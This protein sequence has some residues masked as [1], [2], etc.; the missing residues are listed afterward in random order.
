[1]PG[2]VALR[3]HRFQLQ[4]GGCY[5]TQ[6][7]GLPPQVGDLQVVF[8]KV[9]CGDLTVL[10]VQHEDSFAPLAYTMNTKGGKVV[11]PEGGGNEPLLQKRTTAAVLEAADKDTELNIDGGCCA[12][13]KLVDAAV[14]SRMEVYEL[15]ESR[16][17]CSAMLARAEQSQNLIHTL[18]QV[19]GFVMFLFGFDLIFSFVPALF[20]IVPLIGTWIQLFG[21]L[22]AHIAS[23]LLAGCFWCITVA[24]AWLSMRPA[25]AFLL[26][27][28]AC[29]LI[30]LPTYLA[31]THY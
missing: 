11:R 21:N 27:M 10:A 12:L 6:A 20:R 5:S 30:T 31:T 9:A 17:T 4:Q 15:S 16:E 7:K 2:Q 8:R 26:L 13:C 23:F 25:K 14:E 3:Q 1:M 28:C 29:I 18:L 19:L 24:L 22:L